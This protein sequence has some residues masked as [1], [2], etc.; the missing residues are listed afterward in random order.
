MT[1]PQQHQAP[2][3]Y[4][5]GIH[6]NGHADRGVIGLQPEDVRVG[7]ARLKAGTGWVR[8]ISGTLDNPSA[9]R[10]KKAIWIFAPVTYKATEVTKVGQ[11]VPSRRLV[12]SKPEPEFDVGQTDG[13]QLPAAPTRGMQQAV[14]E[15]PVG[16]VAV[17][18]LQV[19]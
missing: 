4:N 12:G 13:D 9:Q 16:L 7:R 10:G 3:T 11:Q 1:N 5:A 15:A 19:I 18:R 6:L 14:G 17:S 8:P 2:V